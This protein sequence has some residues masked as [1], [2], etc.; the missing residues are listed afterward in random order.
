MDKLPMWQDR[1]FSNFCI[2]RLHDARAFAAWCTLML[3]QLLIIMTVLFTRCQ[4][5]PPFIQPNS[6]YSNSVYC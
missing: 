6:N 3:T 4:R 5:K 2:M 1:G